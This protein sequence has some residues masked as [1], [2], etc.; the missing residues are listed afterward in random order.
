MVLALMLA[1]Y[2]IPLK[3]V[4]A[5]GRHETCR[6]GQGIVPVRACV[7]VLHKL[8]YQGAISVEHEPEHFDPT[9]D[10]KAK[11]AMLREWLSA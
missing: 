11:L 5:P 6:Y 10:C 3:D 1:G 4:R 2:V 8:G 7:E 9:D